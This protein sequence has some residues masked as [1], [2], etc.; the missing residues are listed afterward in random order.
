MK[1]VHRIR[2]DSLLSDR[3]KGVSAVNENIAM[4]DAEEVRGA[5]KTGHIEQTIREWRNQ[6]VRLPCCTSFYPCG[7]LWK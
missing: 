2:Y 3:R 1:V 6:I 5:G 7:V 4:M